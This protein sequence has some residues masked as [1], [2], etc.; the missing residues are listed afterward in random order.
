MFHN[1]KNTYRAINGLKYLCSNIL[2]THNN[3]FNTKL[4][5]TLNKSC[6]TV[7]TSPTFKRGIAQVAKQERLSPVGDLS[8]KHPP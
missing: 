3:K 4:H 2:R 6:S 5:R 8:G 1:T 7:S